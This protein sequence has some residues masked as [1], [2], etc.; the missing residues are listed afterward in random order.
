MHA[1]VLA[2]VGTRV[3]IEPTGAGGSVFL[4][5]HEHIENARGGDVLALWQHL[6]LDLPLAQRRGHVLHGDRVDAVPG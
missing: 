6:R 4:L 2:E 3:L 1:T 5:A